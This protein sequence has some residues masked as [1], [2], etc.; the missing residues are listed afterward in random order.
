ML[1]TMV[2]PSYSI[3][4]LGGTPCSPKAELD[5]ALF[6]MKPLYLTSA[7]EKAARDLDVAL[8]NALDSPDGNFRLFD[9]QTITRIVEIRNVSNGSR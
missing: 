8:A 1:T 4:K 6:D 2:P 7:I 9:Q 5:L 3:G